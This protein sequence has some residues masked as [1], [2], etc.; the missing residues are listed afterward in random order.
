MLTPNEILQK[1]D[2]IK[3]IRDYIDE[4]MDDFIHTRESINK[5]IGR[6]YDDPNDIVNEMM[7]DLDKKL[8]EDY[9]NSWRDIE[10]LIKKY[11][12]AAN[13]IN[14]DINALVSNLSRRGGG[15]LSYDEARFLTW[16]EDYY[17]DNR[18][19]KISL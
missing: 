12:T 6:V 16:Y 5:L 7:R 15:D 1:F 4:N 19:T 9:S 13:L 11:N 2:T 18:F 8:F 3:S 10:E 14:N 17:A